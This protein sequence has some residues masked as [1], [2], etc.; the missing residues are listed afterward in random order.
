MSD[1]P[2]EMPDHEKL[3]AV[4]EL[5]DKMRGAVAVS[6]YIQSVSFEQVTPEVWD[7]VVSFQEAF[8]F[9]IN[10]MLNS[11]PNAVKIVS[12]EA[13]TAHMNAVISSD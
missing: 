8:Q 9:M 3:L 10:I 11:M 4:M 7:T 5:V 13:V 1:L 6:E 12:N 2:Y